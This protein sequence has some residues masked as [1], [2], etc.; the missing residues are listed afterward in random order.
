MPD[1]EAVW[2]RIKQCEGQSFQKLRGGEF[3]Y[4]VRGEV[5]YL[6]TTNRCLSKAHLAKVMPL[7]PL[8]NTVPVQH[9]MAPS[10]IYALL[11]D[12]RIVADE[13]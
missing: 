1:I 8:S 4:T 10:Y 11:T 9:F 13:W 2:A 7:L 5:L 12:P 3:T 6:H